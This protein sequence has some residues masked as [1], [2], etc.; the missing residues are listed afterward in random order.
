MNKKNET[1]INETIFFTWD[2]NPQ[3][4]QWR[5]EKPLKF[6]FREFGKILC[7]HL[8]SNVSSILFRFSECL[9]PLLEKKKYLHFRT[10]FCR[11][12][13]VICLFLNPEFHKFIGLLRWMKMRKGLTFLC[14][15]NGLGHKQLLLI[16]FGI[17]N[18]RLPISFLSIHPFR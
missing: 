11:L 5:T 13:F 8:P 2:N 14:Y 17:W 10:R 18:Y 6:Y 12:R 7:S 3:N 15:K 16:V 1:N 4:C 9:D